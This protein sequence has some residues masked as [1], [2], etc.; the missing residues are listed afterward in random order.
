[1]RFLSKSIENAPHLNINKKKSFKFYRESQNPCLRTCLK[2]EFWKIIN[3][4]ITDQ[5]VYSYLRWFRLGDDETVR[6]SYFMWLATV[7]NMF[8]GQSLTGIPS[9][10]M[11]DHPAFSDK[12]SPHVACTRVP[13]QP[14]PRTQWK[15]PNDHA[16]EALIKIKIKILHYAFIQQYNNNI[17]TVVFYFLTILHYYP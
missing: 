5:I 17:I 6:T 4:N 11:G 2:C 9:S 1:M 3:W 8:W 16:A 15:P 13:N 10:R 7:A 14:H 12:S